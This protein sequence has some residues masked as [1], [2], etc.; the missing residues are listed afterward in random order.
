MDT[1]QIESSLHVAEKF[2]GRKDIREVSP[3]SFLMA[4]CD[5]F[6]AIRLVR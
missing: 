2:V 5:G 4:F 1:C 6:D 3:A